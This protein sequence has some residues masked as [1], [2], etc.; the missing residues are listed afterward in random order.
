MM[1]TIMKRMQE[2]AQTLRG[3]PILEPGPMKGKD[4]QLGPLTDPGDA[5]LD[6]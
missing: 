6:S 2:E 5:G 3:R 4:V 1:R